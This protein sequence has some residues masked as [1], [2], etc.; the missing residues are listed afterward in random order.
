MPVHRSCEPLA[1]RAQRH[2]VRRIR[3]TTAASSSRPR[4]ISLGRVR[5]PGTT[6]S[7]DVA[8]TLVEITDEP[9]VL[10]GDALEDLG[11]RRSHGRLTADRGS[12]WEQGVPTRSLRGLLDDWRAFDPAACQQRLNGLRS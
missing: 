4:A 10:P 6:T 7:R 5:T 2:R 9:F 3:K 11:T 12:G 1:Q 8:Y